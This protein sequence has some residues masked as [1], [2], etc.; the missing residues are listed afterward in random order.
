MKEGKFD[1]T[2][3]GY[4]LFHQIVLNMIIFTSFFSCDKVVLAAI[5]D[6]LTE[7]DKITPWKFG[8]K[9]NCKG[10]RLKRI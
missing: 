5:I 8:L 7:G 3:E 1:R 4:D 6:T 2:G 9:N 10:I